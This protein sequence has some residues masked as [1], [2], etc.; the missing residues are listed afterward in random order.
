MKLD[1]F[2][3]VIVLLLTALS[4]SSSHANGSF[5]H[6][7]VLESLQSNSAEFT[8]GD[9]GRFC[10]AEIVALSYAVTADNQ[11]V[12]SFIAEQD[13]RDHGCFRDP[14]RCTAVYDLKQDEKLRRPRVS[15]QFR[16]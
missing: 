8:T 10:A 15:C 2:V 7:Q 5:T 12:A 16:S 9:D 13:P 4:V 14:I 3:G 6:A 1:S 11:L